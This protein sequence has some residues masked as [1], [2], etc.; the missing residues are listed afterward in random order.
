[1]GLDIGGNTITQASG[2]LT[3]DTGPVVNIL[4][5]GSVVKP[6]QPLFAASGAAA[7]V[8]WSTEA[9][10]NKPVL[11]TS[12]WV[13][14]GNCYSG[15]NTRFT[16]PV[17]GTYFVQ[18]CLYMLKDLASNAYYF[19]PAFAV[20]GSLGGRLVNTSYPN[21]RLRGHGQ[22]IATYCWGHMQEVYD[23]LAGDYIEPLYYSTGGWNG[24][25]GNRYYGANSRFSG[26]LMG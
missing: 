8:Y 11:N 16:A 7:W 21:Y 13:N 9:Q 4:S 5:A 23:L 3:L 18:C 14:A 17:T 20:N 1:M 26:F 24:T 15:A 25:N 19:H 2:V 10:W 22:P 12:I 6:S